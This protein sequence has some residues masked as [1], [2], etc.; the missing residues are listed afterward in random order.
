MGN[1]K[2]VSD[3]SGTTN[4]TYD[5]LGQLLKET[6]GGV[7]KDY[8]YDANGNRKSFKLTN[9]GTIELNTTY[10]YDIQNRLISVTNDGET[11]SSIRMTTTATC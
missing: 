2:Q 7:V 10:A 5:G 1:I 11:T 4:Y 8:T 3:S 9:S 6:K